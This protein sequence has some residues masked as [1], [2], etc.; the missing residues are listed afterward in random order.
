MLQKDPSGRASLEEIEAHH[1]LQGLD[2]AL[3]SPEAPPHW[4]SGAISPSSPRSGLPECGDLLA[5]RPQSQ[6]AFPGTWQPNLSYTLRPPVAEEPPVI[7]T[8]PALQQICEEEDEEEEEEEEDEGSLAKEGECSVLSLFVA[9][10]EEDIEERP[11]EA[12]DQNCREEEE[13]E[14]DIGS[15]VKLLEEEE[16]EDKDEMDEEDS[17]CV[18]SNQPVSNGDNVVSQALVP[19]VTLPGLRVQCCHGQKETSSQEGGDDEETEPNNNTNKPPLLSIHLPSARRSLNGKEAQ[20][21]GREGK[22]EER[23]ETCVRDDLITD[24]SRPH[25]ALGTQDEV[26][27]RVEPGKRHS[28]KLRERLFQFPLC[29]KALA[30]NIPTHNKPKILPLAQYNCCHVL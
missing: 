3:L 12:H 30:F 10:S 13:R 21:T 14:E 29:E 25:N 16:M 28:I 20:K 22:Q 9:E 7:R 5:T 17:G 26:A 27:L 15:S 2:D 8:T 4:L 18:I 24:R 19:P 11:D 6:Q 1:W 23:T